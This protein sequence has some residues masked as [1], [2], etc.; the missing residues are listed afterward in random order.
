MFANLRSFGTVCRLHIYIW[1]GVQIYSS[2]RQLN[3]WSLFCVKY[4]NIFCNFKIRI[5]LLLSFCNAFSA[6]AFTPYAP[7]PKVNHL[8]KIFP[9][10]Y[11]AMKI[12]LMDPQTYQVEGNNYYVAVKSVKITIYIFVFTSCML[13][14]TDVRYM[15]IQC[16]TH[17]CRSQNLVSPID[18]LYLR[19]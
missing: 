6:A 13:C 11:W 18:S 16:R 17:R 5:F 1:Q 12:A 8:R 19:L 9:Y 3:A 7:Y 4:C 2:R 15:L 10:S 14:F